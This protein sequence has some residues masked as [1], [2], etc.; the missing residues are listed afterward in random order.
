LTPYINYEQIYGII[1]GN[2][3]YDLLNKKRIKKSYLQHGKL[4]PRNVDKLK[5][6]SVGSSIEKQTTSE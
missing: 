1:A 6:I 5:T 4:S 3:K 2:R